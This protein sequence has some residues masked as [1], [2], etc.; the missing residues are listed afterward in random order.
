MHLNI[1]LMSAAKWLLN[2]QYLDLKKERDSAHLQLTEAQY[3]S[4]IRKKTTKEK[5]VSLRYDK[6]KRNK[7]CFSTQ[8]GNSFNGGDT[9]TGT[10]TT[11]TFPIKVEDMNSK[12][13]LT[14]W[15]IHLY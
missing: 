6:E 12:H 1:Y 9:W 10:Y 3:S 8:P 5:C 4:T 13:R 2:I 7:L 14:K 11:T 15:S